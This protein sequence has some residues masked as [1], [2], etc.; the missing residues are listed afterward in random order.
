M[1]PKVF[2]NS[3]AHGRAGGYFDSGH[4]FPAQVLFGRL[5]S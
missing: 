2:E 1:P 3:Y 5:V 4:I